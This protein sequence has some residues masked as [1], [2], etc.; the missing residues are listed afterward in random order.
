[1]IPILIKP[2][3]FTRVNERFLDGTIPHEIPKHDVTHPL[4]KK[5]S[6]VNVNTNLTK[7][8]SKI[9]LDLVSESVFHY[10]PAYVSEKT[11]RP[12]LNQRMFIIMGPSKVLQLLKTKGFETW[13]DIVDESYDQIEDPCN[14]FNAVIK[15]FREFVD[16][17]IRFV[18]DYLKRNQNKLRHNFETLHSLRQKEIQEFLESIGK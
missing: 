12:I 17:D 2:D 13:G 8:Y 4:L 9:A 16:L 15:S 6:V 7:I 11:L 10:P 5:Y 1:M 18:K 14:R 3:P